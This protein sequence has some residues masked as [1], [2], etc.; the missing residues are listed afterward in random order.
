MRRVNGIFIASAVD[1]I[2]AAGRRFDKGSVSL[3]HIEI[4]H[5]EGLRP[6]RHHNNADDA[7]GN[8]SARG[9]RRLHSFDVE[10]AGNQKHEQR[11]HGKFPDIESA[12]VKSKKIEGREKARERYDDFRDD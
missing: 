7:D 10:I 9:N 3:S 12:A 6:Y 1:Q 2:G 11:Y 8:E 4:S 5:R